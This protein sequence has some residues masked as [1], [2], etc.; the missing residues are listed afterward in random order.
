MPLMKFLSLK[1]FP[2]LNPY[3]HKQFINKTSW[4]IQKGVSSVGVL[5]RSSHAAC[6]LDYLK[7]AGVLL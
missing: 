6:C 2:A 3:K 1:L 5:I 7:T 4:G